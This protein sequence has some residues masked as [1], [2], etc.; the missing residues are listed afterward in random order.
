MGVDW[1]HGIVASWHSVPQS[2]MN[3]KLTERNSM[4]TIA[5]LIVLLTNDAVH[6]FGLIPD[7]DYDVIECIALYA[8][9]IPMQ[10]S[11]K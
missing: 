11:T 10:P 8:V 2:R 4:T 5:L 3:L 6:D 7:T 9:S 1:H